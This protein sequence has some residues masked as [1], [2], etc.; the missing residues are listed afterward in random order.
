LNLQRSSLGRRRDGAS[1]LVQVARVPEREEGLFCILGVTFRQRRR[2]ATNVLF[3]SG[4]LQRRHKKNGEKRDPGLKRRENGDWSQNHA[5]S[6]PG[7]R[8][9]TDGF[10]PSEPAWSTFGSL[11]SVQSPRVGPQN[12]GRQKRNRDWI[13]VPVAISASIQRKSSE[14]GV[15]FAKM[16]RRRVPKTSDNR[17]TVHTPLPKGNYFAHDQLVERGELA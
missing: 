7:S 4:I 10:R 15:S 16:A 5:Y 6:S 3:P 9:S 11:R 1:P 12:R 17:Q 8:Q 13:N 14:P 2:G